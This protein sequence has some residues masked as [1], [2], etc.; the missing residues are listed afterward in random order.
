MSKN[1]VYKGADIIIYEWPGPVCEIVDPQQ[2]DSIKI[3]S[4]EDAKMLI[5]SLSRFLVV[6]GGAPSKDRSLHE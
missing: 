1:C 4:E 3:K 6:C 2:P 5:E